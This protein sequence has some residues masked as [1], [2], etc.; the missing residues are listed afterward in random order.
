[1]HIVTSVWHW[2]LNVTGVHIPPGGSDWYNFWSGF[3]SDL[4][5]IAILGSILAVYRHHNCRMKGCWRIGRH[6][7]KGTPYIT[8]HKHATPDIHK[9]LHKQHEHEY[10]EQHRLLNPNEN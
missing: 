10:P 9:R 8:C 3:G 6:P 5:E 4:G 7:V 2:I 1:M